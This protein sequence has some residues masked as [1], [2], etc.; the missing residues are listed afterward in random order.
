M[1]AYMNNHMHRTPQ[2]TRERNRKDKERKKAYINIQQST[3]PSLPFTYIH[4][5]ITASM[6]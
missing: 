3:T 5:H 2:C 6:A 4:T 1:W